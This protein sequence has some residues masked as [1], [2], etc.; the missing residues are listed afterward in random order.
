MAEVLFQP[1]TYQGKLIVSNIRKNI[2]DSKWL[3]NNREALQRIFPDKPTAMT[4]L[5]GFKMIDDL[6]ELGV[7][8]EN[9]EPD[10]FESNGQAF[11]N[12]L[13]GLMYMDIIV[14]QKQGDDLWV[15][16]GYSHQELTDQLDGLIKANGRVLNYLQRFAT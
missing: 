12:F 3:E 2:C 13:T 16:K 6:E 10:N 14:F 8:L 9:E 4:N 15:A 5:M 11:L 1:L 7:H